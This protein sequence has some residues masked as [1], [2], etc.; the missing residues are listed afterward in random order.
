MADEETTAA[1]RGDEP[2]EPQQE[3]QFEVGEHV[4]IRED[5]HSK[6]FQGLHGT[7]AGPPVKG[8]T[9]LTLWPV[10]IDVKPYQTVIAGKYL[11]RPTDAERAARAASGSASTGPA[12]RGWLSRIFSGRSARG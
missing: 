12:K 4:V 10:K 11:R 9:A 8:G 2:E 7:I 5:F 3:L 1:A 6:Y